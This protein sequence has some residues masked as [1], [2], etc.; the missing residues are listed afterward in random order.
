MATELRSKGSRVCLLLLCPECV[1]FHRILALQNCKAEVLWQKF[2][3]VL[4][5]HELF[6]VK[7]VHW[8]FGRRELALG[9][10]DLGLRGRMVSC[11]RHDVD[12]RLVLL[13]EIA[14]GVEDLGLVLAK[15]RF[16]DVLRF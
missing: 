4:V 10:V 7:L 6:W 8:R 13:G 3:L 5:H 12:L 9:K 2:L 16:L 15:D 11:R 14:R 1:H